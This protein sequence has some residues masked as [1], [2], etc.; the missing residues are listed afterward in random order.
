MAAPP[1]PDAILQGVQL[2]HKRARA[3]PP[4]ASHS[5]LIWSGGCGTDPNAV[6]QAD[7]KRIVGGLTRAGPCSNRPPGKHE[8][9]TVFSTQQLHRPTVSAFKYIE[10]DVPGRP[11]PLPSGYSSI[12]HLTAFTLSAPDCHN[13]YPHFQRFR[14][15]R[16]PPPESNVT[17]LTIGEATPAQWQELLD[18]LEAKKSNKSHPFSWLASD[19]ESVQVRMDNIS[20]GTNYAALVQDISYA[21]MLS[22]NTYELKVAIP[23]V[24]AASIPVRF[25]FGDPDRSFHIRLPIDHPDPSTLILNLDVPFPPELATAFAALPSCVGVNITAD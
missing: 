3:A 24:P 6:T 11:P 1:S 12:D 2:A 9:I 20:W 13:L 10:E 21:S 4:R 14:D 15:N 18:W 22:A 23:N 16:L 17:E 8:A 7:K 19:T 5:F 25:F